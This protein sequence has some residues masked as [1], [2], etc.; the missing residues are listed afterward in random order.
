MHRQIHAEYFCLFQLADDSIYHYAHRTEKFNFFKILN[1][2]HCNI[3]FNF[4]PA[5]SHDLKVIGVN[6]KN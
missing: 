4:Y 5:S 3:L 1:N 6:S 2:S